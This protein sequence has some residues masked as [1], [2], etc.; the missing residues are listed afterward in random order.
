VVSLYAIHI[1]IGKRINYSERCE[2]VADQASDFGK[3]GKKCI[4]GKKM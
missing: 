3:S 2:G 4:D 1:K